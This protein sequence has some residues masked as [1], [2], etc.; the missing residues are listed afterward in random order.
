VERRAKRE[1]RGAARSVPVEAFPTG[2]DG[3]HG[4]RRCAAA[5]HGDEERRGMN[6]KNEFRVRGQQPPGGF[7]LPI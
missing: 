2:T 3:H 5:A 7:H 6:E 1:G 4:R